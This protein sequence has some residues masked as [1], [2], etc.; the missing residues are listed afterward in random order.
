MNGSW[1]RVVVPALGVLVAACTANA[2]RTAADPMPS[3]T[4][5]DRGF[6]VSLDAR[7]QYPE[8]FDEETGLRSILGTP[9]LGVG[10][11]RVSFVL[12]HERGLLRFPVVR[13]ASYFYP[14]GSD[15]A[16]EGPV[17]SGSARFFD[18][19]LGTRG[20]YVAELG[21]DRAGTWGLE[22]SFPNPDGGRT[23]TGFPFEVRERAFAPAVGDP[24]PASANRTLEDV[25]GIEQ[26]TTGSNPDRGL[27]R[28]SIAD[29]IAAGRPF[30]LVFA[31]PAFCTS[32]FCGPQVEVVSAL[33]GR[34]AD[35]ADFIHVDLYANPHE[36]RGDL[37]RGIR[38]PVLDEWSIT[39]DE[40]T[41][42]VDGDGRI[43]GRFES[44][45]SEDELEPALL[46]VLAGSGTPTVQGSE[47]AMS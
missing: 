3:A 12:V 31:S 33:R 4:A 2:S 26:L 39:S 29:A 36:I 19:P 46:K 34:R 27:Y 35:R 14:E 7:V 1:V 32:A 38:N 11:H 10:R 44:F 30:V 13:V 40:W 6:V 24:A 23:S 17:E 47:G 5:A 22:A 16:P 41:F 25:D 42:V 9:D 18:F 28:R 15:G 8:S 45:V 43:A 37:G 21:F 20:V